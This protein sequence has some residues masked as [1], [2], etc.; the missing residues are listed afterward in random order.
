MIVRPHHTD[1]RG[2]RARRRMPRTPADS[3][4]PAR[5][6]HR[7]IDIPGRSNRCDRTR[8]WRVKNSAVSSLPFPFKRQL[9]AAEHF[10]GDQ[11]IHRA[12]FGQHT[13]G[14]PPTGGKAL[15]GPAPPSGCAVLEHQWATWRSSLAQDHR[16]QQRREDERG[17]RGIAFDLIHA[18][19]SF[20]SSSKGGP[21]KLF[22]GTLPMYFRS[23]ANGRR[24]EAAGGQDRDRERRT[25]RP[26]AG[27]LPARA[28][29]QIS[30]QIICSRRQSANLAEA[31][32]RLLSSQENPPSRCRGHVKSGY[33]A[34]T[35]SSMKSTTPAG[36]ALGDRH[37]RG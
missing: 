8:A 22:N 21:S 34:L 32:L 15:G 1:G 11:V 35:H 20:L 2:H 17:N 24:V 18:S 7:A 33:G 5:W 10:L 4:R 25:A 36:T 26:R 6:H 3:C 14:Y 9:Q 31:P 37:R 13:I 23:A 30:S 16:G 12:C 28:G 27:C 19:P 29:S